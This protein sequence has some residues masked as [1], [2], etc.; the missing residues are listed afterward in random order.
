MRLA[1]ERVVDALAV[2]DAAGREPMGATRIEGL[3]GEE[4]PATGPSYD[5]ADLA[6]AIALPDR[7]FEG[8]V[9]RRHDVQRRPEPPRELVE[10]ARDLGRQIHAGE[11][12]G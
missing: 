3:D 6:K 4:D 5:H 8:V 9:D 2:V 12:R 10:L 11:G 1:D 7:I